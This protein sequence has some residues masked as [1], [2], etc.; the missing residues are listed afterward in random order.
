M[1]LADKTELFA[2][3]PIKVNILRGTPLRSKDRFAYS[4]RLG[5]GE[6]CDIRFSDPRVSTDHAEVYWEDEKWWLKDL[7]SRNGT[8]LD[9]VRVSHS[10]DKRECNHASC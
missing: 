9:G 2:A 10:F 4:F 1:P 3:P 5:R 8:F 7:G 6:D